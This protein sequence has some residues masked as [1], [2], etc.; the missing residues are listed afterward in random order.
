MSD[1]P[2]DPIS[3]PSPSPEASQSASFDTMLDAAC[4]ALQ[5]KTAAH[6]MEKL[7]KLDAKLKEIEAD[8]DAIYCKV[9]PN[10]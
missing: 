4:A 3:D 8:I 2:A 6:T 5:Q 9:I 10:Y 7:N 1:S